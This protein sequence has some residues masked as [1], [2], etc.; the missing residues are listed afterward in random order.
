M[1]EQQQ[2]DSQRNL[3]AIKVAKQHKLDQRSSLDA[4]L[5]ALK[6]SNGEGR[7]QLNHAR[8]VL[9]TSQRE[10]AAAKLRSERSNDNLNNFD[11]KLKKTL[12]TVRALHSKRRKLDEAMVRLENYG[13]TLECDA[14]N[15]V[16]QVKSIEMQVEN[17]RHR[18]TLLVKAIQDSKVKKQS[19]AERTSQ[20]RGAISSLESELTATQH[21]EAAVKISLDQKR[22]EC[23]SE[24]ERSYHSKEVALRKREE[25][26]TQRAELESSIR[27]LHHDV[28]S[29]GEV[30]KEVWGK[31]VTIQNEEG[32]D[33][34]SSADVASLDVDAIRVTLNGEKATLT[35]KEEEL[36]AAEGRSK[37]L[38]A[39][40][41]R[42]REESDAIST[43]HDD[44]VLKVTADRRCEDQR[45]EERTKFMHELDSSRGK[46][47]KL[48]ETLV[49]LN[50]EENVRLL[51]S[52]NR[53]EH[54]DSSINTEKDKLVQVTLE[55]EKL[56]KECGDAE[57]ELKHEK[58]IS[59]EDIV[60]AKKYADD[61]G[62]VMRVIQKRAEDMPGLD[63]DERLTA[64]EEE[65]AKQIDEISLKQ[66]QILSGKCLV[67]LIMI[68]SRLFPHYIIYIYIYT[69]SQSIHAW[70]A[71]T[72]PQTTHMLPK[73]VRLNLHFQ[74]YGI[75]VILR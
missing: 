24:N 49:S 36:F 55:I 37:A 64:V 19:F 60:K 8:K 27:D 69:Y 34:S 72:Y 44:M 62:E 18:E 41:V 73:K 68:Y 61:A 3:A 15:I 20:V 35:L 25:M 67:N 50:E 58:S 14:E 33:T 48:E 51:E 26:A 71:L 29:K 4:K 23:Q 47:R 31:C 74:D 65:E 39:Q 53:K 22:M 56:N 10:L 17:A 13:A 42:Y 40:L 63:G 16:R 70:P 28:E 11:G 7:F 46:L 52:E 59:Q 43:K 38:E 57:S 32:L 6:Y 9:S 1:L 75:F 5:S 12:C 54:L 2:R 45:G 21:T 30:L 66:Q